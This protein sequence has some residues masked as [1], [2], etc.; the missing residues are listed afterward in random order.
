VLRQL[1]CAP[2]DGPRRDFRVDSCA[3]RTRSRGFNQF[4]QMSYESGRRIAQADK[5]AAVR[6]QPDHH[7]SYST[8]FL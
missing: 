3:F 2:R 7:S 6:H 1:K 4:G 5:L 8:N